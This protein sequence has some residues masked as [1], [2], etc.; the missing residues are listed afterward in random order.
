MNGYILKDKDGKN[1]MS[2]NVL[3]VE[4]NFIHFL[5]QINYTIFRGVFRAC[6][7]K[8]KMRVLLDFFE[9]NHQLNPR[10]SYDFKLELA[11]NFFLH[12]TG[13]DGYIYMETLFQEN[14]NTCLK[15]KYIIDQSYLPDF[16]NRITKVISYNEALYII[17]A[18]TEMKEDDK[19]SNKAL[20]K[21]IKIEISNVVIHEEDDENCGLS[22]IEFQS[23][24]QTQYCEIKRSVSM[25]LYELNEFK[26]ELSCFEK[27]GK[28]SLQFSPLGE[29]YMLE[30]IK[31]KSKVYI[32]GTVTDFLFPQSEA[33]FEDVVTIK[34]LYQIFNQILNIE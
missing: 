19:T 13:V 30:F 31:E 14:I 32:K 1:V 8:E 9:Y 4:Q 5:I 22:W 33:Y 21:N 7:S 3:K 23:T 28:Q 6:I 27:V 25:Y 18:S 26:E 15:I 34:D 20:G 24:I 11:T 16:I 17:D 12:I 2:W 29:F 10:D